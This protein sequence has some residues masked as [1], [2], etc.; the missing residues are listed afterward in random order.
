MI[1]LRIEV[2]MFKTIVELADAIRSGKF[3]PKTLRAFTDG[4]ELYVYANGVELFGDVVT[5]EDV[6]RILGIEDVNDA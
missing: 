4:N 6:A 5:S 1:D 3:D 2:N